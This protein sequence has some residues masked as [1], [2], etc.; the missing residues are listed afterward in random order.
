M[1]T[2]TIFLLVLAFVVAT[3]IGTSTFIHSVRSPL[4]PKVAI[5]STIALQPTLTHAQLVYTYALEW[6]ESGG[7]KAVINPKDSDNTPSYYSWQWKPSTFKYFGILY[8]ILPKSE[9]DAEAKIE[10]ANYDTERKVLE[11]MVL[12]DRDI[13]FAKQFPGCTRKLGLPPLSTVS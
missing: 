11:A 8:G 6:C 9:T 2:H 1:K 3:S 5:A 7:D 12:H 10:M 4:D 13:N